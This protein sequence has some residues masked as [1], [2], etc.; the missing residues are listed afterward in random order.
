MCMDIYLQ[1]YVC[2]CVTLRQYPYLGNGFRSKPRGEIRSWSPWP[3]ALRRWLQHHF[4]NSCDST[5]ARLYGLLPFPWITPG[6]WKGGD[7]SDVESLSSISPLP[8][9][10]P[11]RGPPAPLQSDDTAQEVR[12]SSANRSWLLKA[13]I[14]GHS[15]PTDAT[16]R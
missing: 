11:W 5:G 13:Q 4:G 1:T 9:P 16:D 6:T 15:W 12:C 14:H 2:L 7:L 10:S 8:R 3:K